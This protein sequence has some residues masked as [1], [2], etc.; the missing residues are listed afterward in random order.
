MIASRRRVALAL[1]AMAA[2]SG[3][4]AA[5][6]PP[7]RL[8]SIRVPVLGPGEYVDAFSI[9]T[10]GIGILSACHV[11][12]GWQVTAGN[13][14]SV[15]GALDGQASV[16]PAAVSR[17]NRNTGQ[18]GGMVLVRLDQP[19]DARDGLPPRLTGTLTVLRYG[20]EKYERKLRLRPQ[21]IVLAPATR[22][23]PPH[24]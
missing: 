2:S 9:G 11:P 3:A 20:D 17:A 15:G 14:S 8:L 1:F 18:F 19:P 6:A 10:V 24:A 13:D 16:T 4:A 21:D 5:T 23:P 7:V 22:C 12:F